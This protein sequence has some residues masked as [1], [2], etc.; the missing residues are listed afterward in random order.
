MKKVIIY[1][2]IILKDGE[3]VGKESAAEKYKAGMAHHYW[4]VQDSKGKMVAEG[5]KDVHAAR[6]WIKNHSKK[7]S[8]APIYEM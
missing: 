7:A 3:G 1:T 5:L 6:Q 4:I 2:D 8:D